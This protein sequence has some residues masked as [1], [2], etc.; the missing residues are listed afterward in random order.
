MNHIRPVPSSLRGQT[1]IAFFSEPSLSL[2]IL[3]LTYFAYTD[4]ISQKLAHLDDDLDSLISLTRESPSLPSI[5]GWIIQTC[6]DPCG[7]KPNI[8]FYS[9]PF[10]TSC[11]FEDSTDHYCLSDVCNDLFA[12]ISVNLLQTI[13]AISDSHICIHTLKLSCPVVTITIW[14]KPLYFSFVLILYYCPA[15]IGFVNVP[16]LLLNM[17]YRVCTARTA[18]PQITTDYYTSVCMFRRI[19]HNPSSRIFCWF[20]SRFSWVIYFLCGK[21]KRFA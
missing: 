2:N 10:T 15:I 9:D 5:S 17:L 11:S 3:S 7:D 6:S 4:F 1:D 18:C 13:T 8:A 16:W 14:L 21:P 12:S 19:R 20:T